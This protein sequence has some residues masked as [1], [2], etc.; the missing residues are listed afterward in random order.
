MHISTTSSTLSQNVQSI[1]LNFQFAEVQ[2]GS[3]YDLYEYICIVMTN[4][5]S[6]ASSKELTE[7]ENNLLD[8]IFA[9]TFFLQIRAAPQLEYLLLHFSLTI[10]LKFRKSLRTQMHF[11]FHFGKFPRFASKRNAEFFSLPIFNIDC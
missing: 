1:V 3:N 7:T 4:N 6:F 11:T 2:I 8:N 5:F 10:V 9:S